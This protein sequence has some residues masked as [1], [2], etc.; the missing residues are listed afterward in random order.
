MLL[1][2][3]E[4]ILNHTRMDVRTVEPSSLEKVPVIIQAWL[5]NT[6]ML[7]KEEIRTVFL[8]QNFFMKLKPEQKNW[9]KAN[10]EQVFAVREPAFVWN[11]DMRMNP[12]IR[13]KGRDKF[14]G[15]KGEM[16]MKMNGLFTLGKDVGEKMDEGTLQ[17]YL[18]EI[19][20]FPSAALSDYIEWKT[21]DS[22]RVMATM[23]YKGTTGS[24]VFTFNEEGELKE[25]RAMR[26]KG[27]N[28]DA[29]RYPWYVSVIEHKEF[30]GIKI[31]SKMTATWV[32]ENEEWTWCEIEITDIWYNSIIF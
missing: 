18:G 1:A 8:K 10:A 28:Q 27:N 7:G 25:Y 30:H 14:I 20:W 32:L 11:V 29:K 3:R 23:K 24:G 12:L 16:L 4:S 15:G 21:L 19:V 6:G 9:Y 22:C 26:Y 2:E 17:R 13:I 5:K 31:P